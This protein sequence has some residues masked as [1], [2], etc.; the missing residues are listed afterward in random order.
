MQ[1]VLSTNQDGLLFTDNEATQ[2]VRFL[3]PLEDKWGMSLLLS[4]DYLQWMGASFD[5]I[6]SQRVSGKFVFQGKDTSHIEDIQD[7]AD[8]LGETF[9]RKFMAEKIE[10][11]G[12][13][14]VIDNTVTLDFQITG[15]EPLWT[16]LFKKGVLSLFSTVE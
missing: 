15:L 11:E 10:Y 5:F 16:K 3:R 12:D 14:I 6:D 4:A 7:D 1:S 13:V 8:F 9:K 2:F